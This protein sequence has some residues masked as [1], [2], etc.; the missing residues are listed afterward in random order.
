MRIKYLCEDLDVLRSRLKD[1][2]RDIEGKLDD[3]EV[4][5]LLMTI[6][7]VGP[8]TAAC[9]IAELGDPARFRSR[10]GVFLEEDKGSD[11]D[12]LAAWS[13]VGRGWVD[14]ASVERPAREGTIGDRVVALEHRDLS[15][16][17]LGKP[18]PL[19]V[20]AV[21]EAGGLLL[22]A[23]RRATRSVMRL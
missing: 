8:L 18:I 12:V 22:S 16:L 6:D 4:G 21:G 19:V 17:L 15:G 11:H 2:A 14:A 23:P 5:K 13:V 3:H 20:G 9:L 7:G 10:G 1:L